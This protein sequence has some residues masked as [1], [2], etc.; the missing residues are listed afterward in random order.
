MCGPGGELQIRWVNPSVDK[1]KCFKICDLVSAGHHPSSIPD[2]RCYYQGVY[3]DV[4][5]KR[6]LQDHKCHYYRY[7]GQDADSYWKVISEEQFRIGYSMGYAQVYFSQYQTEGHKLAKFMNSDI[8]WQFEGRPGFQMP[9]WNSLCVPLRVDED[10]VPGQDFR[11]VC[12]RTQL[13]MEP[14][15][16]DCDIGERPPLRPSFEQQL[17]G[18]VPAQPLA[19]DEVIK[20]AEKLEGDNSSRPHNQGGRGWHKQRDHYRIIELYRR[21][22]WH[23]PQGRNRDGHYRRNRG[24]RRRNCRRWQCYE[25]DKPGYRFA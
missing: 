4:L 5:I 19:L 12:N 20:F 25:S 17:I 7:I 9:R 18:G 24:G 22:Q 3:E 13:L 16:M 11:A 2:P 15:G 1:L 23:Q 8:H 10:Q 6:L 21:G 14:I